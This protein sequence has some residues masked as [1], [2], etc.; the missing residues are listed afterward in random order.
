MSYALTFPYLIWMHTVHASGETW[1]EGRLDHTGVLMIAT[2]KLVSMAQNYSDGVA[3]GPQKAAAH[4]RALE[5]IPTF[6]EML[7]FVMMAHNNFVGPASEIKPYLDFCNG[8][9]GALGI[10]SPPLSLRPMLH[11]EA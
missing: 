3:M 11:S 6:L 4:P 10:P 7:S 2:L 5:R 1:R 9:V 8:T